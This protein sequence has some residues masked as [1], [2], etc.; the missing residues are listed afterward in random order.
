M[1]DSD[2]EGALACGHHHEGEKQLRS[3]VVRIGDDDV[4]SSFLFAR[5]RHCR[6][7]YYH[8]VIIF[9]FVLRTKS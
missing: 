4:S 6:H 5:C 8:D 7:G 3:A 9:V 2:I 1:E